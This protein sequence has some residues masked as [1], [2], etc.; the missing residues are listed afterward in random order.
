MSVRTELVFEN[1][2]EGTRKRITISL[3]WVPPTDYV[4]TK[5]LID[6]ESEIDP[7]YAWDIL[8]YLDKKMTREKFTEMRKYYQMVELSHPSLRMK[9]ANMWTLENSFF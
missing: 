8:I 2:A 5:M 1:N 6:A 7:S 9:I 3:G 4:L